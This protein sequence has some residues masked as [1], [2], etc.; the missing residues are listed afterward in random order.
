MRRRAKAGSSGRVKTKRASAKRR[1]AAKSARSPR[2]ATSTQ[3]ELAGLKR[4]LTEALERQTAT[5][6]VLAVI[7]KSSG[8]LQPVF[9]AILHNAVHLCEADFGLFW[10]NDSGSYR[11]AA[12]HHV[13]PALAGSKFAQPVASFSPA[14]GAGRALKSK[15]LLHIADMKKDPGYL[16][17]EDRVVALVELGGAR[18][19]VFAPLVKD[20]EAFGLFVLYRRAVR[21]HSDKQI[22]LIQSFASQAIIAIENARLLNA[23]RER[24][25]D[26]AESLE[27]QT[28]TSEVLKIISASPGN[29]PPIFTAILENVTRICAANFGGIFRVEGDQPKLLAQIGF[30]PEFAAFLQRDKPRAGPHHPH[31]RVVATQRTLHIAD[32]RQDQAYREGDPMAVGGVDI[33]G[34]RTLLTV[35]MLKDGVLLGVV[36]AFRKEVRP[37]AEKQIELVQSFAAQAVIA[38]ENARLF[39]ELK[40]RTDDLTESLEQQ[41]ATSEVLRVISSSPGELQPVFQAMLENALRI[42]DAKFGIMFR[43]DDDLS[44][45][46]ATLNLP[47]AAEEFFRQRGPL[48]AT[49]DSDLDRLWKS[50]QVIHT[51][52]MSASPNPSRI[53]R[54][55]GVRTQIMVPMLKDDTLIGAFAIFRQEIRPFTDK[56]TA[57]LTNFAA[58]AVIAIE[59]TRLLSELRESLEQQTATSDLLGVISTSPGDLEPVFR[60]MLENATRICQAE[61][62]TLSLREAAALRVVAMHNSPAAYAE[63][64]RREPVWVPTGPMGRMVEQAITSKRAVQILDFA[65]YADEDGVSRD[66]A[67]TTGARS[68]ILVP[69]L[70][71]DE[72]IGT[73]AIYRQE[74]R[75]F[76]DKQVELL[77]NFASQA[78]IAVENTRLLS[79]LRESLERQTAT[80]EVLRVISSSPGELNLVFQAMLENAVRICGAKVGLLSLREGDAFR[81]IATEGSPTAFTERRRQQPLIR[82]TPGHNLERLVRTKSVVH[83]PDLA[84]DKE[85]GREL[86]EFA[87]ARALLNVPLLKDDELI[88]SIL[89]Y[90]EETGPFTDKQIDLVQ[91]FAAQAVIA[92]ENTRLLNE[93]RESLQQQTATS[94]VL[95]AISRS[96]FDLRTILDTLTRSATLL[97][98]AHDAVILLLE[99]DVLVMGSHHGPISADWATWPL[100]RTWVGGRAFMDRKPIHVADLAAEG[101]EF[102]DG[103]AMAIR[104]GHRSILAVPLLRGNEAI[105]SLTV[106]RSE[107]RPFSEKQ[108]ELV[109]TFADQAVIAIENSRLL[110]ELQ[111]SLDQQTATADVLRIISSSPGE[112]DPVFQAMLDSATRLCEA[113]FGILLLRDGARLRIVCRHVPPDVSTKVFEQGSELIFADN[114]GHPLTRMVQSKAIVHIADL[115]ADPAYVSR[116]VRVV[117]FVD[118]LGGRAALCVPMLKDSECVGGFVI[119]R[120]QVGAFT[121]KQID[122]VQ[123]FAAQAVIAIENTRLLNELRQSLQQQTA[124]ADVLKIISRSTF[125][126]QTVLDT[127]VESAARLCEAEMAVINRLGET[128]YH[129]AASYGLS[130]AQRDGI[131]SIPISAGRGTIT[132]RVAADRLFV[133]VIDVRADPEF[134]MH[135]WYDKVGSR[136]MLGV[137]LLRE[138]M[139]IGVMVLMRKSVRPFTEAQIALV[140]TFAD[141][142]GIAIENVRLFEAEQERTH[143]LANSLQ[144]LHTAQDRLVQTQKLASLGQLTAGIAHE[145]KNPLNFVNNFSSLSVELIDELR[146]TLQRVTVDDKTRAEIDE[147][148]DTLRGNLDKIAQHGKRAD[149]IVKNMLMHSREGSGEHRVVDVNA[150]V[151]ESLNLA[152][153]GARAEKQNFNV[154]LERAY[155]QAAGEAD[156]FPQEITRVLLNLIGNGF[157]AAGKRMADSG[158]NSYEPKLKAATKNLGNR[159]EITI[160]DNGTGIPPEVK[161]KMFNPFFTTKPAGEGTGLGLSLSHDIIVKQHAGTIEVES[162]PGAFTEIRIVLPRAAALTGSGG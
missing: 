71:E 31:N 141:Q 162:E 27:Q 106:R 26:L 142:A 43:F 25:D 70:K 84:A 35:P 135:E 148:A 50:K 57:L 159:V 67:T 95:K 48:K 125:D 123:N 55:A 38:I 134:T 130:T 37:F 17:R 8:N 44:Y 139:P 124:T 121:D 129:V 161:E 52:D 98:E 131:A 153:H 9:D 68:V 104:M 94:D 69:L 101:T 90:R 5:A 3:A 117:A 108:I 13:P 14:S 15:K 157:Y 133:H 122:L 146:E 88:G 113:P 137:P 105:G 132:G 103:Q 156:V 75:P 45:A 78:V 128:S 136:T 150:M 110:K 30:P 87:G 60:A 4:E 66:F 140:N 72:V 10:L 107:I 73:S 145:I 53:A 82:P 91:N 81:S 92:I 28:A 19:V 151:E 97:C 160:R 74:V 119:F 77:T 29:L 54:M 22:A 16:A 100:T 42:C 80:S 34:I 158:G 85:A 49:P 1:T 79:E 147:V 155:D 24:T 102:P 7:A 41:T 33:G 11:I 61:F 18:S 20:D 59:N 86:F 144:D 6:D 120:E 143:E 58:Q 23:L 118:G 39:N 63:L 36:A 47:P 21:P 149:S 51:P 93:L 76:T 111:E 112:L 138:G 115:I 56:Q 96:T 109:A 99:G 65:V 116:N 126:L 154:T 62:G 2:L 152:F 40:Q 32:Y 127:L 64:R 46:A 83:I 114:V 12:V 89:F